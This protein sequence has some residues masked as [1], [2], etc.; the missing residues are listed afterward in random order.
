MSRKLNYKLIRS[1]RRKKTVSL[2]IQRDGTIT[3]HVPLTMPEK[4]ID[5]YFAGKKY[6]IKRKLSEN[7]F[8][9]YR[10][11]QFIQGEEFL[12]LGKRYRLNMPKPKKGKHLLE[13]TNNGFMLNENH[14]DSAKKLFIGW[15]RKKS[16]KVISDRVEFH[17]R[18]LD[19][20]PKAVRITNAEYRWGSCSHNNRLS[21]TWRLVM[22]PLNVIDYIVVHELLHIRIKNHSGN[23]W[24][25]FESVM[26]RYQDH[27]QWLDENGYC[28]IL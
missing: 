8:K 28:L 7:K 9:L 11:K 17:S 10:P 20:F 18:R 12:Y 6:W 15:Y 24:S 19:L 3:I 21:F 1:R 25:F 22:A 14:K 27:R 13:L 2:C 23:F 5:E 4:K 26:P 16:H